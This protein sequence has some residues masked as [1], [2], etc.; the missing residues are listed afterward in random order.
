MKKNALFALAV[1][2]AS[3]IS[4]AAYAENPAWR[5]AVMKLIASKQSYPPAAEMRGDEG[6]AQV[7][8]T[9]GAGGELTEV[10]LVQKTGSLVLDREAVALPKRVGNFPAPPGGATTTTIPMVW[11]LQ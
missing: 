10:E 7:K 2:A 5:S 6:T 3:L 8:L 9:I 1:V 4:S 11:R